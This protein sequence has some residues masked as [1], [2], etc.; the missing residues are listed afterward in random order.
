MAWIYAAV[1]AE[2]PLLWDIKSGQS[3]IARATSRRKESYL[4]A[5]KKE[6][7]ALRLS[8]TT[9]E[10]S[11]DDICPSLWISFMAEHPAR[12]L[13]LQEAERA[14]AER[15]PNSSL[16]SS[17]SL[18]SFDP[19]SFSWKIAQM[20]LFSDSEEFLWSSLRWG[21]MQGGQLFQP[22]SLVP[23]ICANDSGFLPTPTAVS[24]G[25][26]QSPSPGAMVRPSLQGL[27]KEIIAA[28]G[29]NHWKNKRR[30]LPTP[31]ASDGPKNGIGARFGNGSLK[32]GALAARLPTPLSRDGKDGLTPRR[33]G[34]HSPSVAVAVAEAGHPGYLNPALVEVIMGYPA[35]WTESRSWGTHGCLKRQ[36]SPSTD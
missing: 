24:Y 4:N 12:T 10:P 3:P 25:T 34:R 36:E 9:Y 6:R 20:S 21:T 17:D 28:G 5:N 23:R 35:G 16:K 22:K 14:W 19:G 13:A 33:H 2:R 30:R 1:E 11:T 27:A 15:N 32:L 8:G 31:L 29:L 26:N 18:A 7:S